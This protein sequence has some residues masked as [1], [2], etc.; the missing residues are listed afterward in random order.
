M[1][2]ADRSAEPLPPPTSIVRDPEPAR[3]AAPGRIRILARSAGPAVLPD[4]AAR[5][6]VRDDRTIR[7]AVRFKAPKGRLVQ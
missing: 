7:G 4:S 5:R 1:S 3:D 6:Y 2:A